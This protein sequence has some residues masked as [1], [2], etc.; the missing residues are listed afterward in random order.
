MDA[1]GFASLRVFMQQKSDLY[2]QRF[3]IST[4]L[5]QGRTFRQKAAAYAEPAP[6]G[7]ASRV[8]F[9]EAHAALAP[10]AAELLDIHEPT[11]IALNAADRASQCRRGTTLYNREPTFPDSDLLPTRRM[12]GA[13]GLRLDLSSVSLFELYSTFW[14]CWILALWL[15]GVGAQDNG[16]GGSVSSAGA[17]ANFGGGNGGFGDG[18][19]RGGGRFGHK[20]DFRKG[21]R[22]GNGRNGGQQGGDQTATDDPSSEADDEDTEGALTSSSP[23]TL[24]VPVEISAAQAIVTVETTVFPEST[25]SPIATSS[26]PIETFEQPISS[27]DAFPTPQSRPA[28]LAG[29]PYVAPSITAIV[30]SL[31][32]LAALAPVSSLSPVSSRTTIRLTVTS[33]TTVYVDSTTLPLP[34]SAPAEADSTSAQATQTPSLDLAPL[35]AS[36]VKPLSAGEKAGVGIGIALAILAIFGAIAYELYRRREMKA[37]EPLGSQYEGPPHRRLV[38][39]GAFKSYFGPRNKGEQKGDPEWSI[40]SAE[41]VFIVRAGSIK[42]VESQPRPMTPPLPSLPLSGP[43][44][45]LSGSGTELL[46]VGMTV[47]ERK[48][49]PRLADLAL[50]NPPVSPSSFPSPPRAGKN[51]SWPLPE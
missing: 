24:S 4:A 49:T 1:A 22:F 47:P 2:W 15:T 43:R 20:P 27:A 28:T 46:K 30:Q 12:C 5:S 35:P 44:P 19:D 31:S 21:G 37:R 17:N 33:S 45:A 16:G 9:L 34:T 25:N 23:V 7:H 51:G 41:K 10:A 11:R 39:T 42:S 3:V 38:L 18:N 29:I 36:S 32:F 48:P 14:L 40:E 26:T 6:G 13:A 50:S 8:Q